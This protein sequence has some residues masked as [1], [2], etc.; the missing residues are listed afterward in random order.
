MFQ[1]NT[2]PDYVSLLWQSIDDSYAVNAP[3]DSLL[4][5]LRIKFIVQSISPHTN[6][7]Q[8][9]TRILLTFLTDHESLH[10][11]QMVLEDCL[12]LPEFVL[13]LRELLPMIRRLHEYVG[14]IRVRKNELSLVLSR[15]SEL[16]KYVECV[17]TL[18]SLLSRFR[19]NLKAL[20]WQ[21]LYLETRAVIESALF[22]QLA[23]E[24]PALR[25]TVSGIVSVTI[26]VNLSPDL[27]PTGAT[28]LSLNSKRFKGPRF[29]R[30]FWNS[31]DEDNNIHGL[32]PLR[33]APQNHEF[34]ADSV[35]QSRHE[36]LD[37]LETSALFKDLA[38]L[39]NDVTAPIG[40]A[41]QKYQ[42][43]NSG[44]LRFIEPEIAFY[45]GG[46]NLLDSLTKAGLAICRPKILPQSERRLQVSG[47]YNLDLALRLI[48]E[49]RDEN[50]C[51]LVIPNDVG[52]DD[53]GRILVLTGPNRGGKTTYTQAI[54]LLHIMA[55]SGL[56]V[57]AES[58]EISPID[59]IYLHFPAE[60]NPTMESGRLG[61]EAKRLRDIF[62]SATRHSLVLLNES[63]A[64]TSAVESYYL[65]RDVVSCLRL[66][67]T[68]AVF[69]T[70]L[71]ELAEHVDEINAE[72]EGDSKVQ[73]LVSTVTENVDEI[74][75]TYKIIPA[76]PRG[77]SYAREIARQYGISFD[78]IQDL[79]NQRE[80]LSQPSPEQKDN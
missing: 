17:E 51:Q 7:H 3:D 69:V 57:P 5:D 40:S 80:L 76:P 15:L 33:T 32:T 23:A 72:I 48:R 2:H 44:F 4:T 21:N 55:Q 37:R 52:F 8:H 30:K 78:Q 9:I 68:R 74:E 53:E 61:E 62:K 19:P 1:N 26:G 75:R 13:G 18:Y 27:K 66:L 28:L 63:L 31:E 58:A 73:S 14:D 49:H 10:Y 47:L 36:S 59:T 29:F 67:G 6:Y 64:S 12:N 42:R 41:L 16:E 71:H 35:M 46:V 25:E 39:L 50:I 60:E 20:A 56:M 34:Y 45:V 38:L 24:L 65:A 43:I 79:L 11:R 77:Q 70:H 22:K 54:G